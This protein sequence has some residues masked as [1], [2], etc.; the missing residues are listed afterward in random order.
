[1]KTKNLK[2]TAKK[3]YL[4][5]LLSG[6]LTFIMISILLS[7]TSCQ[8]DDIDDAKESIIPARFKVDIPTAISSQH[9][10]LKAT[11][12]SQ[13][14][15]LKGDG[16][17]ENLTTFIKVGEDAAELTQDIFLWIALYNLNR[18]MEISFISDEDGRA[19]H[20]SI[21]ENV[22]FEGTNWQ[23][24]LTLTDVEEGEGA[25]AEIGLQIF[26]NLNPIHGISILNFYNLNRNTEE[27]YKDT[28][29]RVEYSEVGSVNYDKHMIVS[30]TDF[31]IP[32][33]HYIFG[34]SSLKMFV[35]KK[36][37]IVSIYGNSLHPNAQFFTEQ[38]GFNWAFVAAASESLNIAVAEVG[39]PP[40]TLDA[41][42]RHT[43]LEEYSIENVFRNQVLLTWPTIDPEV[44]DAFLYHAKAPGYFNNDGFVQGGTAPSGSYS[45][46]EEI[47]LELTP[48][49]PAHILDLSVQFN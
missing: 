32:Q 12:A 9:G 17:Y 35:G 25:N 11:G 26:W 7:F 28:H 27:I 5:K 20:I 43:L 45:P 15:T 23:Y 42:D 4:I 24:N 31:P 33:E 14:D 3:G 2:T 16:I 19:K 30:L 21:I 22:M 48:Y 49:N 13:V 10:S 8:K 36:G 37:D 47:I 38:T 34:I 40:M 39:L 44:L 29:Y 1:M 41:S 6:S 18:P 46:L